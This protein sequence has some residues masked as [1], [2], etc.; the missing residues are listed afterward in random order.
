MRSSI[1]DFWTAVVITG[2]KPTVTVKEEQGSGGGGEAVAV[3]VM[4]VVL[5]GALIAGFVK[6][7][8]DKE[9]DP[10]NKPAVAEV[11]INQKVKS[12]A[13]SKCSL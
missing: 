8:R 1:F 13:V 4:A 12:D 11:S 10:L 3:T 5:V 9:K 7:K 2:S 6:L